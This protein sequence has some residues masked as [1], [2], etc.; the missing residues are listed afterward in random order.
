MFSSTPFYHKLLRKYVTIMGNMLDDI[1]IVRRDSN[2]VELQRIRVPVKYGPKENWVSRLEGD[3]D[4]MKETQLTLPVI[5]YEISGVTYD[6]PRQQNA[7][8]RMARGN[9]ATR[10]ASSY[11]HTPYDIDFTVS[12]YA[13]NTDDA[14]Q[15]TEQI[16]PYFNPDYT[17]TI[18]PIAELGFLKDI[19]VIMKGSEQSITYEGPASDT[20]RYVNWTLNFTMK[21]YFFGPI[22]TPKIIRKSIAN[23]FNDPSLVRG[24]IIRINTDTGNNGTF[25]M[26]DTIFQGDDY[27]TA[28]AYGIVTSWDQ[29]NQKLT[30]GAAQGNFNANQ[31]IRAVSTNATYNIVSFDATPLKLTKI[32]IEPDPITANPGDDY[33]YTETVTEYPNIQE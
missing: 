6:K 3:P 24:Y 31:V 12:I 32:V 21:A 29:Q 22:T 19:P 11:M 28:R 8:L 16:W 14:N 30:I 1:T 26:M 9:T 4:L 2:N 10:V 5:S 23:I 33:G 18:T 7:L 20:V 13:R 17:V 27:K 25:T 15:I